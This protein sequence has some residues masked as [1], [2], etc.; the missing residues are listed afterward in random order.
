[1]AGLEILFQVRIRPCGAKTIQLRRREEKRL[2]KRKEELGEDGLEKLGQD[3]Q[4]AIDGKVPAQA[5]PGKL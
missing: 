4:D 2:A 5:A 3:L 1:M